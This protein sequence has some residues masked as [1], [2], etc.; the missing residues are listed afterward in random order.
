[1][2]GEIETV[3]KRIG[4]VG[5]GLYLLII[6]ILSY[7]IILILRDLAGYTQP[8]PIDYLTIFIFITPINIPLNT[9]TDTLV[10]SLITLYTVFALYDI[11]RRVDH[12]RPI[13]EMFLLSSMVFTISVGLEYIQDFIGIKT[14][15]PKASNDYLY[16]VSAIVAPI[17]EEIGFRLTVIGLASIIIY[18]LMPLSVKRIEDYIKAFFHPAAVFSENYIAKKMLYWIVIITSIL[19]GL[20]HVL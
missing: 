3:I 1:V 10:I 19:F 7:Y 11:I 20:A 9:D 15:Y 14:G 13:A 18:R 5:G 8:L 12:K 2:R 17:T 6:S 16:F 4:D